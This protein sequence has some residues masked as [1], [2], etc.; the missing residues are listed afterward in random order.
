[1]M[2]IFQI[3]NHEPGLSKYQNQ[4]TVCKEKLLPACGLRVWPVE[5]HKD[6][7]S[8]C[9]CSALCIARKVTQRTVS[10]HGQGSAASGRTSHGKSPEVCLEPAVDPHLHT[11]EVKVTVSWLTV[12]STN[13]CRTLAM[14]ICLSTGCITL[15]MPDFR[16]VHCGLKAHIQSSPV[17]THL[18]YWFVHQWCGQQLLA[19]CRQ[20]PFT[21][22]NRCWAG[23]P[24]VC[25]EPI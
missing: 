18:S 4:Q 13:S 12:V 16:R 9:F 1:M 21:P 20:L 10:M 2:S 24:A 14:S 11:V 17:C 6:Q 23:C 3:S 25:L 22:A 8:E 19:Q 15:T 7:V 5:L